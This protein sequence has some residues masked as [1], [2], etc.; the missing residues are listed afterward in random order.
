MV[1]R[2]VGQIDMTH[3]TSKPGT[4]GLKQ[5]VLVKSHK[6]KSVLRGEWE[7]AVSEKQSDSVQKEI[8]AV[9]LTEKHRETGAVTD[10]KKNRP[11]LHQR[12]RHRLTKKKKLERFWCQRGKSFWSK[13]PPSVQKKKKNL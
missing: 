6:G 7:S 5:G 4:K 1:R 11:L 2:H 12:R 3:A 10:K 9:S 13:R 8:L